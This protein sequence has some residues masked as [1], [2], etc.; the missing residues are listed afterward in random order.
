VLLTF[1]DKNS[2]KLVK[3]HDTY[4]YYTGDT[5]LKNNIIWKIE[6]NFADYK[7]NNIGE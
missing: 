6:D 7:Y 1:G 3:L 5:N 4:K 2:D